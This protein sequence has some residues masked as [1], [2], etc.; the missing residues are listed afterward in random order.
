MTANLPDDIR[1]CPFCRTELVRRTVAGRDRPYCPRCGRPFFSDPKLAVAV[2]VHRE[3]QIVL[4][5]RAID[6]GS[7]RWSF[8]SGF[9]ERGEPVEEAAVREV[10]EETGLEV[11]INRLVGLYSQRGHAV[12]LAVYDAR[13]IAGALRVSDESSAVAWFPLDSLPPL[14]F[15]H[16]R[17]ILEDWRR[18]TER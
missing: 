2:I 5:Q 13:V 9:V 7:G 12:V 10:L 16:D 15:P 8:P 11:E 18:G 6:P 3:G 1:Y 14:A 4:Q 17:K